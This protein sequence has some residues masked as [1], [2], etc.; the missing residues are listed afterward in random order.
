MA[1]KSKLELL[2]ELSD[3]LFNNKLSQVQQKLSAATGKM[4]GRLKQ[5]NATQIKIF[6]KIGESFDPTKINQATELFDN[7]SQKLDFTTDINKTKTALQQMGVVDNIDKVSE[8][9]N[10]LKVRFGDDSIQIAKAANAMTKQLGG[11]FESNLAEIEKGYL[12]GANLNGDMIDQ[13]KEYPSQI[14]ELGLNASQMIAIMAKAGKDGIFSDKAIDSIKEANLS[15]KEM[16]QPQID[17]LKG[18]GIE[19]KDLAGKTS[20]EAVQMIAKAMDGATAQAKQLALTDIF[21]GAGED[22]GMSFILGLGSMDLDPNNIPSF[23]QADDG[24]KA[25]TAKIQSAVADTLGG[26]PI[27]DIAAFAITAMG[28]ISVLSTLNGV[29]SFTTIATKIQTAAQWLWN[30]ALTANPIGLVIAAIAALIAITVVAYN[31]IGWF[32]GAIDATWEALKGFGT[33]I[34]EYVINRFKELLAGVTGIGAAMLK[35]FQGDWQGAWD[36]GK[37]A[38]NNLM[39]FE[40]AKT[41]AGQLKK[42]GKDAALA[43]AKGVAEVDAE[44]KLKT[45]S[46]AAK[47]NASQ[48]LYKAPTLDGVIADDGKKKKKGKKLG[49]KIE[50]TAGQANQVRHVTVNIDAF[51][52]GG[53][54]VSQ[55]QFKGMTIAE[56]EAWFKEMMLRI[57]ANT[58]TA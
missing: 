32:R 16:G 46:T 38:I 42:V 14:K 37:A 9:I 41:A 49:D 21:K 18:I 29:I 31:K 53:I 12:K 43:Y 8:S 1:K 17:A 25:F 55:S 39:G 27:H 44:A 35:F 11:T 50:E 28:L 23:K 47:P 54:N 33:V 4:E 57:I 58:E 40:S 3:K 34:K 52:K 26:L 51:N 13:L 48:S 56:V 24:F 15:L 6:S 10:N 22:A 30:A 45:G 36:A 5:F 19:V 7:L 20:F 2:I